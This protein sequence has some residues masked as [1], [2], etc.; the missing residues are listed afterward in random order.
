MAFNLDLVLDSFIKTDA[1]DC[2]FTVGSPPVF[3]FQGEIKIQNGDNI[4]QKDMENIFDSLLNEDARLEF[5]STL[6]YN[7]AVVWKEHRFRLNVYR[8][9]KF[10]SI[11][12]RRICTHIPTIEELKIPAAYGEIA[13]EKRGLVL[14]VGATGSGKS[15]SL[16]AM[17]GHR[18]TQGSGH[19]ITIE[20]PIEFV[21][22]H[23]KC[24]FSQRDIGI[25]TY[26]YGVALKNAL[27]QS[28]DVIVIGEIRDREAMEHAIM[29]SETGHLCVATLHANNA[30]QAIER[31]I[32]FFPEE[33]HKQILLNLSVNIKAI[34][35]QRLVAGKEGGRHAVSEIMLNDGIIRD[36][37]AEGR[38]KEIREHIERGRDVGMQTFEQA[39]FSLYTGGLITEQIAL[40]EADNPA[41][42]RLVIKQYEMGVA[43]S[44]K[45]P[46]DTSMLGDRDQF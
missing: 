20:D 9:R 1:S 35:S 19:V 44:A 40:A 5:E 28:P 32:N 3:R 41:N 39:L 42:L 29:F 6:E 12:L 46:H 17:L 30:N 13:L 22:E 37:I 4:I 45:K 18:N 27:R 24:I 43:M 25:D 2:Y 33:K 8:Q 36:L 7:T 31:I 14:I 15:T 11:V 21:H 34:F 10:T 16:A 26:S 38:I 23:G